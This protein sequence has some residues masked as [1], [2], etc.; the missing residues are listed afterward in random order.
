[1]LQTPNR[2]NLVE[3]S[4]EWLIQ[5]V[6]DAPTS[7]TGGYPDGSAL[8]TRMAWQKLKSRVRTGDELWSF[9]NPPKTWRKLG[10]LNGFAIL[11]EGSVVESAAI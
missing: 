6:E 8:R 11:R 5:R 1:M 2:K 4:S 7:F 9:A 3:I 10:R